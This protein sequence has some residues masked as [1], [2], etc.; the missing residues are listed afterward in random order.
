MLR[1]EVVQLCAA[2][3]LRSVDLLLQ[4]RLAGKE[5]KCQSCPHL[6]AAAPDTAAVVVDMAGPVAHAAAAQ[7]AADDT[8]AVV[9][10]MAGPLAHAAA[11]GPAAVVAG[12][13]GPADAAAAIAE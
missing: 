8:A 1:V 12:L 5:A 7:P 2:V 11:A 10:G 3:R 6:L 13:P 4:G 9:V